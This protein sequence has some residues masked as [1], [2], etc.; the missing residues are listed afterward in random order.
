MNVRFL[1]KCGSG[2][3]GDCEVKSVEKLNRDREE[4][5]DISLGE[6]HADTFKDL[7]T[8]RLMSRFCEKSA[9]LKS[10]TRGGV[11]ATSRRWV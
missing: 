10:S 11:C 5:C 1:A 2:A 8:R 7:R 4:I 9:L 6:Q 3:D